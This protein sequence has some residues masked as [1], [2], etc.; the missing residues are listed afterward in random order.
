LVFS[1]YPVSKKGTSPMHFQCEYIGERKQAEQ[2]L[3]IDIKIFPKNEKTG[4]YLPAVICPTTYY[5][6]SYTLYHYEKQGKINYI[7]E[8]RNLIDKRQENL[9]TTPNHIYLDLYIDLASL[10]KE[11]KVEMT[12][13]WQGGEQQFTTL[14]EK[15]EMYCA[16]KV[17]T[18]PFG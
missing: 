18:N 11:L 15:G 4:E 7:G 16:E 2:L 6:S 3:S 10:S 8:L 12:V 17:R 5:Q 1:S 13:K 14:M 9:P